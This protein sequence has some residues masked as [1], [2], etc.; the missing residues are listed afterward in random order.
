LLVVA[1]DNEDMVEEGKENE[2]GFEGV[3][4]KKTTIPPTKS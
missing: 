3:K 1:S 2:Y 4:Q